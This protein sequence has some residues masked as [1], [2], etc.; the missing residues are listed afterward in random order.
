MRERLLAK[1]QTV[2]WLCRDKYDAH[3]ISVLL[4][5]RY[6]LS[7]AIEGHR[8]PAVTELRG[9]VS[10]AIVGL[11]RDIAPLG[12]VVFILDDFHLVGREFHKMFVRLFTASPNNV[13]FLVV[14]RQRG[15]I[16]L[17]ALKAA[18]DLTEVDQDELRLTAGEIDSLVGSLVS[19]D[20]VA[21]L[22]ERAEGGP[23]AVQFARMWIEGRPDADRRILGFSG[24]AG[25]V[26]DYLTEQI[27]DEIPRT[28]PISSFRL[29]SSM[30]STG[31][32]SRN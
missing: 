28:S 2:I 4:H 22:H 16:P 30:R 15:L 10:E 13:R 31:I 6:A 18:G 12:S 23:V 3:P 32:W 25:D 21:A 9:F 11:V 24:A 17:T 7:N 27:I 5:L 14:T 20:A 1:G 29:R 19:K 26:S 8:K